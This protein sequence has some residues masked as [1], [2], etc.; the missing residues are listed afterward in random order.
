MNPNQTLNP[1]TPLPT[2]ADIFQNYKASEPTPTQP[3]NDWYSGIS[4]GAY[5]LAGQVPIT[6]P[7]P[8]IANSTLPI[9]PF[10]L[11]NAIAGNESV[12]SGNYKAIGPVT[13]SGDRAL[14]R[15]Q[16][17]TQN[18]PQWSK[19]VLGK[20]ISSTEFYNNPQIQDQ[21]FNAKME[22]FYKQT[23]N[24]SDAISMW[25]SG[26]PLKGNNAKDILGTSTPLYVNKAMAYIRKY[27]P[28]I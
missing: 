2:T 9:S 10:I 12:G 22:Q 20:S 8:K 6:N 5:R 17:M 13:G 21:I 4:S 26:K 16:V 14:G 1:T 7:A 11:Q 19:E 3:T 15:Y 23:G 18:I 27:H 28:N 24:L 25:F